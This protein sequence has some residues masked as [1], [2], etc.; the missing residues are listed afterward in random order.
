MDDVHDMATGLGR[1]RYDFGLSDAVPASLRETMRLTATFCHVL[2]DA[3]TF[4]PMSDGTVRLDSMRN[5]LGTAGE[6]VGVWFVTF[7]AYTVAAQL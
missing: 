7:V 2:R 1:G 3:A 4:T 6:G 5:P